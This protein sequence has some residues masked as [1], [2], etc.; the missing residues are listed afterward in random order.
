MAARNLILRSSLDFDTESSISGL[1]LFLLKV[2]SFANTLSLESI[3]HIKTDWRK[4]RKSD[5]PSTVSPDPYTVAPKIFPS[6]LFIRNRT[7]VFQAI[8][9]SHILPVIP[10]SF[11]LLT[12]L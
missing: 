10:H 6:R 3:K 8:I 5:V 4:A 11:D 9:H 2:L 12:P 7:N 1:S